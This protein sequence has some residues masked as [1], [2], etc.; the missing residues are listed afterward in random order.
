MADPVMMPESDGRHFFRPLLTDFL[1]R[2]SIP[3]AFLKYLNGKIPG[4]VI[5]RNSYDDLK[6]WRVEVDSECHF[7]EGWKRFC[8]DH[9]LRVGDFLVFKHDGDLLFDVVVLDPCACERHPPISGCRATKDT[10]PSRTSRTVRTEAVAVDPVPK[11]KASSASSKNPCFH[12][13]LRP[14]FM[15]HNMLIFPRNF[16]KMNGLWEKRCDMILIDQKERHWQVRLSY[17]SGGS[18]YIRKGLL[19]YRN[20]NGLKKGDVMLCELLRLGN[21]PALKC[22]KVVS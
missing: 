6:V 20:A 8:K 15:S 2:S 14:S 13:T 21:T 3:L 5:L 18:T 12:L 19:A 17:K 1:T 4:T 11:A 16:A 9:D 7:K 10:L 22:I